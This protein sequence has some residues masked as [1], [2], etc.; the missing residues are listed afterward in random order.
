[1]QGF[2]RKATYVVLYELISLMLISTA[3]YLYSDKDAAHSGMLGVIT[4]VVAIVWNLAYNSLFELW[5]ARQVVRGRSLA[6]RIA[7]AVGFELGLV[8]MTLPL[9]AWWLELSLLD[10]FL[11]DA[12]LTLFFMFFTFVYSWCFDRVFGLPLAAQ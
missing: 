1:M 9:F 8:A 5:E 10:A 7:H 6:R 12:G 4:V 11:L 2:K 3:F